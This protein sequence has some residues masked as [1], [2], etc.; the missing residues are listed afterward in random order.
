MQGTITILVLLVVLAGLGMCKGNSNQEGPSTADASPAIN[1]PASQDVQPQAPRESIVGMD[2]TPRPSNQ[3][4]D[5]A[6]APGADNTSKTPA[7]PFSPY[8][9]RIVNSRKRIVLQSGP[10]MSS[11]NVAKIDTGTVVQVIELG[12]KWVQVKTEDGLVGYV[13]VTQ[14]ETL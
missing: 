6:S 11:K 14:L 7:T 13:R 3:H 10:R 12:E 8:A 2:M 1:A 9:A 4:E 5:E